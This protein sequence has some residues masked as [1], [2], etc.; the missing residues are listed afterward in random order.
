MQEIIDT[1][2]DV[3]EDSSLPKNIKTKLESAIN[4]LK[5]SGPTPVAVSRM[6]QTLEE[7]SEDTNVQPHT[8]NQI[9][10][11]TSLLESLDTNGQ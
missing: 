4:G 11:V 10:M 1:L 3:L 7:I 9:F 6:L 5:E 2:T 8:R